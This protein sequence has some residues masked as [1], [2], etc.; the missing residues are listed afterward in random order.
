MAPPSRPRGSGRPPFC[1][2]GGVPFAPG[3]GKEGA[4]RGEGCRTQ[5]QRGKRIHDATRR[6]Q[7]ACPG[8]CTL[9]HRHFWP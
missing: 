1:K 4:Y 8:A 9:D 6:S 2:M 3:R 7:E 5:G